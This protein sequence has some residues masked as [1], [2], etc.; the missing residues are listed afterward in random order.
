LGVV[1]VTRYEV[2]YFSKGLVAST[3]VLEAKD[4]IELGGMLDV[5]ACQWEVSR[6]V[7]LKGRAELAG[8][9]GRQLVVSCTELLA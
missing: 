3:T 9:R 4:L 8:Y 2:R 5:P 1:A 7:E 6:P